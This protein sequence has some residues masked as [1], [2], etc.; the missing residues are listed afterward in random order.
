MNHI[1]TVSDQ[2]MVGVNHQRTRTFAFSPWGC[3]SLDRLRY[4]L[5]TADAW[6]SL[7]E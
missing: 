4:W 2:P 6:R 5:Q 7:A 3:D 1:L